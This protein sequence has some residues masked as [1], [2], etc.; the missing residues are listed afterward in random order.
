MLEPN[1]KNISNKIKKKYGKRRA[2][3]FVLILRAFSNT[4][5]NC[6]SEKSPKFFPFY[7]IC[8]NQK[9]GCQTTL[10]TF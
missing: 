7:S 1:V 2:P 3:M 4:S 8:S 9:K 10:Q 6:E 5:S